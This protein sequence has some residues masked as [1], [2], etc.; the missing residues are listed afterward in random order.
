MTKWMK[1]AFI[2]LL[3]GAALFV[4]G[5]MLGGSGISI[6]QNLK[7]ISADDYKHYTYENKELE[8][9][10][11]VDIDV[12]NVPVTFLPSENGK[13]GVEVSFRIV[14]EDDVRVEV[15]NKKLIIENRKNMFW[16]SWD[17]SFMKEDAIEEYVIVYLPAG[18]YEDIVVETSNAAI[19]M[20]VSE[21][22]IK[23]LELNSSNAPIK[24]LGA[25]CGEIA[26][27]TSNASVEL[28]NVES[29]RLTLDT[30]NGPVM[31]EKVMAPVIKA[32]T[33]NG[34]IEILDSGF[35]NLVADTSNSGITLKE[36]HL[37][38]EDGEISLIT[39]NGE[40]SADFREYEE[41]DFKVKAD[42][43]NADI[44]INDISLEKDDYVT[45]KGKVILKLDTS[46]QNIYLNFMEN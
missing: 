40:I 44:Y 2:C 27:D 34:K 15:K 28:K 42:T 14:N 39:S 9:F 43:S 18:E 11:A 16:M 35:K 32:E 10:R 4:A 13:Y 5:S 46:N 20:D 30:S 19:E 22:R 17:F 38:S 29:D 3:T 8:A 23:E 45:K 26:L 36:P 31:L 37:L 21:L 41:G 25:K 33:S 1:A 12:S 7:V 24:I 6:N